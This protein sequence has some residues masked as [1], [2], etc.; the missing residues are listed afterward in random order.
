MF[1]TKRNRQPEQETRPTINQRTFRMWT[2]REYGIRCDTL[3]C[4]FVCVC[5]CVYDECS[6]TK[7]LRFPCKSGP[8]ISIRRRLIFKNAHK[9]VSLQWIDMNVRVAFM[10]RLIDS[11]NTSDD[12]VTYRNQ[13]TTWVKTATCIQSMRSG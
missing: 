10:L 1:R 4:M 13:N 7:T 9:T 12:A 5:A 3:R 8:W 11:A 2:Y 6:R